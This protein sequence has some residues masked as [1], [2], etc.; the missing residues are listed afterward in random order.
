MAKSIIGFH[1][2]ITGEKKGTREFMDGLNQKGIP[3]LVKGSDDTGLCVQGLE[4]SKKHGVENWL[5][6][7]A[8]TAGQANGI[9]YDTPTSEDYKTKSP[10]ESAR[11]HWQITVD[12]W[13]K[14]LKAEQPGSD[15][16][17]EEIWME[18]INE[19]RAK[20]GENETQWNDMHPVDWLGEFML[21]YAKIANAEGYKVCGPS[22]NSGEPEVFAVNDYE[23]PGMLAYLRYCAEHPDEAALSLHEYT[24]SRWENGESWPDWYPILF[25]RAEAAI[26]AADKHNIPRDFHI[27]VTE[28]GFSGG[29]AP[30]WP[31]CIPYLTDY[32]NWAAR[33]P[34]VKGVA[35]W[36]LQIYHGGSGASRPDLDL[37]T[38]LKDPSR[39]RDYVISH[40]FSPGE[41]PAR[42]HQLF[43]STLP[44]SVP[45]VG[46]PPETPVE[47]PPVVIAPPEVPSTDGLAYETLAFL[48]SVANFNNLLPGH[49]FSGTWTIKNTGTRPWPGDFTITYYDQPTSNT[50]QAIRHLMGAKSSYTLRELTGQDRLNPG[51]TVTIR[52][53]LVAPQ[54]PGT[55]AFHWQLLNS[56]GQAFG[57]TRWLM[58]GVKGAVVQPIAPIAPMEFQPGMNV[59]PDA[60]PPDIERLRG[61]RWV[62]FVY[63]ASA[64]HRTVDQAFQGE[65]QN[66]VQRYANAGIKCLLILNQETEW[67]NEPWRNGD[68]GQYA[69]S[70]ARATRRVAELCAPFGDMVAYQIWNE[71]DSG[72]DNISAI[73]VSADN[74]ALILG[75]TAEAIRQV[76]PQAT[77]VIGG[78]N[79]GPENA[80]AYVRRVQQRLDG[81]LPVDALAYHPYGRY[82]HHDPFYNQKFGRLQDALRTFKQAYPQKPLWITEIGVADNNPIGSEHYEKIANYMREFFTELADNHAQHV[83]VLIWFAWSD[84]MRNAGITTIDRQLKPHIGDAFRE[85]VARG[86]ADPFAV[87]FTQPGAVD[88]ADSEYL[89]FTTTLQ[90]YNVVPAGTT[91]TNRWVFRNTGGSTWGDGYR[92]VYAPEPNGS[93]DPMMAETSYPLADMASP[94]PARPGDEVEIRLHMTAPAL[95]GRHYVSRWELRDQSETPFGHVYAEITVVPPVTAGTNVRSADMIFIADQTIPDG[96]PLQEGTA[97][98]KQWLVRNTGNRQWGSGFRLN[99][100]E[101]NL[102]MAR[103]IASHVVPTA[104]KGEEVVLSVPMTAPPTIANRPTT[105]ISAWRLQDDRGNFFGEPIWAK[106]RSNSSQA[107][108]SFGRFSDTSGWYS[109]KDSRWH[110]DQLGHGQQTLG[111]W[112]CLLTCYAMM[113]TAYGVQFNPAELNQR[114]VG[115]ETD[116]G[117]NGSSVQFIAPAT[118]LQ[119]LRQGSNLRSW[120]TSDVPT[121]VWQDGI[122]P[123]QRIDTA[124]AAGH[125]VIAQVDF[126][127]IDSNIDQHWVIIVQRTPEGDDYLILD[128]IVP[129]DQVQD[130]PRSLMQKYGQPAASRSHEDNLRNTIKSA[131]V[132]RFNG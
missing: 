99:F 128:P 89:R 39:L 132:Y 41:Q 110:G 36:A 42:T 50:L 27:F 11:K 119:G 111:S 122:D 23:Q 19:P 125:A 80:V 70:L 101:G 44:G 94:M 77:V 97:F 47:E 96:T 8:S 121:T 73:G 22:F 76:T 67:G 57:G 46:L 31:D 124:L 78:L 1:Y 54:Q 18:P 108:T 58:I 32:N 109:Q 65:Y 29:K 30:R 131:L 82:V 10:Q 24:W 61:L 45:G 25:G 37:H 16:R 103:G 56:D 21:E 53:N 26:A 95:F 52:L 85:L 129:A 123:I 79:T 104:A 15:F 60:H 84:L 51:E 83:P 43:G 4:Y 34:Q 118:L 127:P 120:P 90:D 35:T 55:Y 98:H 64:K 92:L 33:W 17:K 13:R 71:E 14:D 126:Q 91:F 107:Q 117:F 48:N 12:H 100:V 40:D 38:W 20:L 62:R 114:L 59:N 93:S 66:L 69:T 106:I 3:F 28:W 130:Q 5:I 81:Q 63:K 9:D 74:F 102:Q 7:R 72:E 116:R 112:G 6:Y 115:H 2:S 75:Q 49:Q 105:F 87:A 68:W 113:L 86:K 88:K